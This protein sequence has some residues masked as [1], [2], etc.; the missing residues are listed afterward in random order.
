MYRYNYTQQIEG[1][2]PAITL[3]YYHGISSP[4]KGDESAQGIL[5]AESHSPEIICQDEKN[6]VDC[7]QR[8]CISSLN[9]FSGGH[10]EKLQTLIEHPGLQLPKRRKSQV[11]HR[12]GK[13]PVCYKMYMSG[14]LLV[15]N[16]YYNM[17]I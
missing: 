1:H 10:E 3:K 15:N 7:N 13:K 16:K 4:G 11:L 14:P 6:L 12:R 2:T 9:S 8:G 5:P 17:Q